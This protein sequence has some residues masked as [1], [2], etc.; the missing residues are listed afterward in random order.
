MKSTRR[1]KMLKCILKNAGYMT[2]LVDQLIQQRQSGE[3]GEGTP[4][5]IKYKQVPINIGG[6]AMVMMPQNVIKEDGSVDIIIN[7]KGVNSPI[8][9][10]AT[11]KRAVQVS[12]YEPEGGKHKFGN[13]AQYNHQFVNRV[14]NTIISTLQKANPEKTIKRGKLTIT[15]WSAGGTSLKQI[16]ANE[17]QVKGGVDEV[18]FSDAL[19]SGMG[20]NMDQGLQPVLDFARKAALDPNKKIVLVSTGV[21]PGNTSGQQPYAS[22]YQTGNRIAE[23]VGAQQKN[24]GDVFYE[25]GRPASLSQIGGFQWVQLYPPGKYDVNQM[26]KQHGDAYRWTVANTSN[27]LG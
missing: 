11:G 22:T 14:I 19:H 25:G 26:K 7:F 4:E 6:N 5:Q 20:S 10:G 12:V 16:L 17:N 2:D 3:A 8:H 21:I 1:L 15:G 18:I 27:L 23:L 24:T 9:A 13:Y